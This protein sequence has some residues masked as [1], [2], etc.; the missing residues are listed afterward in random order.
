MARAREEREKKIKDIE[1]KNKLLNEQLK[2]PNLTK[3]EKDA[4]KAQIKNNQGQI[5]NLNNPQATQPGQQAPQQPSIPP[6][7]TPAP[8]ATQNSSAGTPAQAAQNPTSGTNVPKPPTSNP[9]TGAG[10]S[11]GAPTIGRGINTSQINN[12]SNAS[13][14]TPEQTKQVATEIE[15]DM[16]S[17]EKEMNDPATRLN[18]DRMQELESKYNGLD[19]ERK[20]LGEG[21]VLPAR[22]KSFGG[23][24]VGQ[25]NT[26]PKTFGQGRTDGSLTTDLNLTQQDRVLRKAV[27]K[28]ERMVEKAAAQAKGTS[29][30]QSL[31]AGIAGGA[32]A[33]AA[34]T[35]VTS[36]RVPTPDLENTGGFDQ[37]G[38]IQTPSTMDF[39]GIQIPEASSGGIT[40]TI[41]NIE[42]PVGAMSPVASIVGL[43]DKTISVG[44][45]VDTV[46]KLDTPVT[47]YIPEVGPELAVAGKAASAIKSVGITQQP[48]SGLVDQFG[49]PLSTR[50][51][52]DSG[53][54]KDSYQSKYSGSIYNGSIENAT[55]IT[56]DPRYRE[57][58]AEI[59]NNLMKEHD[60]DY[61]EKNYSGLGSDGY[62]MDKSGNKTSTAPVQVDFRTK[63]GRY[64]YSVSNELAL[65]RF[66][67]QYPEAAAKYTDVTSSSTSEGNIKAA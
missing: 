25:L 3:A 32:A 13:P 62:L 50:T 42:I 8:V 23:Q 33:T 18:K 39:G 7:N 15:N 67:E 56:D 57:I 26:K 47:R 6:V 2:N 11:T 5:W 19:K 28:Q 63:D 54:Q 10:G 61:Y 29:K 52:S 65:Q 36:A 38:L 12:Q 40:Q 41:S 1:F 43:G 66:N 44:K 59:H 48:S 9:S 31:L 4:L 30:T 58:H 49:N 24:P 51:Q 55:K 22:L 21:N 37:S 45:A 35:P 60:S 27:E 53:A 16:R 17:L 34:T 64:G 46:A 20:G 14:L